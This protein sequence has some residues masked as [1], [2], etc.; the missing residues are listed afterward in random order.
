MLVDE[1]LAL[2]V[3]GRFALSGD[4]KQ[5]RRARGCFE[6]STNRIGGAGAGGGEGDA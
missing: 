4:Y 5:W 1:T 2:A 6:Q 3:V